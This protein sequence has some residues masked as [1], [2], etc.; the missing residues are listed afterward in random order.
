VTGSG[1]TQRNADKVFVEMLN[2]RYGGN[3][4]VAAR[5]ILKLILGK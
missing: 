2:G 5:I 1:D 3:V 4:G